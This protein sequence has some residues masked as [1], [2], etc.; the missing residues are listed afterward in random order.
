MQTKITETSTRSI[1]IY[2]YYFSNES[3]RH[4]GY[5]DTDYTDIRS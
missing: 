2:T 3:K 5:T 4:N 1:S